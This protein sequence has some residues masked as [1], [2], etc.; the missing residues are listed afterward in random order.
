MKLLKNGR[1]TSIVSVENIT[2]F[3]IW[4]Y[5]AGKEFFLNYKAY[6]YLENKS[7]KDIHNVKL[8]HGF[9]LHW[10]SLDIDLEIDN[11]EHPEKYPLRSKLNK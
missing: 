4:L 11:L 6:P 9:H 7:I 10:P 5:V 3:G 2:P 8:L 1:N